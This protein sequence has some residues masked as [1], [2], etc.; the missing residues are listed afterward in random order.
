MSPKPALGSPTND[1]EFFQT[2]SPYIMVISKGEIK[3]F[4][5]KPEDPIMLVGI[6]S[7]KHTKNY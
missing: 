3:L 5:G 7:G 4:L 2:A 1:P 6:P